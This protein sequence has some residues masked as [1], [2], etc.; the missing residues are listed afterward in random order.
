M[1]IIDKLKWELEA[2]EFYIQK[3][4]KESAEYWIAMGQAVLLQEL[5][6][7]FDR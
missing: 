4:E 1:E 7:E 3:V 5:L 2:V 6:D